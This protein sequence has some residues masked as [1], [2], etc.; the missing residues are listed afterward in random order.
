MLKTYLFCTLIILCGINSTYS[1]ERNE[2]EE[3]LEFHQLVTPSDFDMY[4]LSIQWGS[5]NF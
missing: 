1:K 5:K 3:F 4:V 2:I